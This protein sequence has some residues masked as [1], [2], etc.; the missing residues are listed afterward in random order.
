MP[1]CTAQGPGVGT[2][3]FPSLP[4][5]GDGFRRVNGLTYH[6]TKYTHAHPSGGASNINEH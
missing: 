1:L 5:N 6:V 2:D 3:T 4:Q